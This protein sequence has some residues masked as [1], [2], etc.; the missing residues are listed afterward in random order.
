MEKTKLKAYFWKSHEDDESGIAVVAYNIKEAKKLGYDWWAC[1]VGTEPE[2]FIEQ[3]CK[4]NKTA[5]TSK[6]TQSRTIEGIE[7]LKLG[8]YSHLHDEDCEKC[9]HMNTLN[10]HKNKAWCSDCIDQYYKKEDGK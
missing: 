2:T 1:E 3:R 8:L 10:N 4:W 9:G 6:E 5:D 7:G